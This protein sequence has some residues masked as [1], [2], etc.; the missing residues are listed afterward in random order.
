[1]FNKVAS[2]GVAASFV[3]IVTWAL[4]QYAG[5]QLPPGVQEALI[6]IIGWLAAFMTPESTAKIEAYLK[7]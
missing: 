4:E 5:V 3:A 2:G 6:V 7:K 1:M